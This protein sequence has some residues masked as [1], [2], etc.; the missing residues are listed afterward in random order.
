[1]NRIAIFA[2]VALLAVSFAADASASAHCYLLLLRPQRPYAPCARARALAAPLTVLLLLFPRA[3]FCRTSSYKT[4]LATIKKN[5]M[6]MYKNCGG[7]HLLPVWELH[8]EQ[9]QL[10]QLPQCRFHRPHDGIMIAYVRQSA[11]LVSVAAVPQLLIE[12]S[13]LLDGVRRM[14]SSTIMSTMHSTCCTASFATHV[15]LFCMCL[16]VL[17]LQPW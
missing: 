8:L 1:M 12:S 2:L 11:R 4:D 7:K 13:S 10:P 14:H 3:A 15:H 6:E 16:A 17:I 5:K 9:Q